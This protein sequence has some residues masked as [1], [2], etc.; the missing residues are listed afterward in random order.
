M[1]MPELELIAA[2]RREAERMSQDEAVMQLDALSPG[3]GCGLSIPGY[4][5]LS[6]IHHGAQGVVYRAVQEVTER[7]VAVKIIRRSPCAAVDDGARFQ[8]E[9]R[10]LAR[11]RHPSIVAI[12]E[13][14]VVCG[15]LYFV[16][17][18]V[19][20]TP[21]DEW[22]AQQ[23][24]AVEPRRLAALFAD[25]CDAV[26]AAHVRGVIHRD[27]KP[28]NIRVDRTATPHVLD[29]GLAKFVDDDALDDAA[30]TR[31]GQFVGSLPWASPEQ[32]EGR[33]DAVDLRTDVYALGVMLYQA[34]T[35]RFPHDTSGTLRERLNAI[36]HAEPVRARA[37][38]R[39]IDDELDT[40]VHKCLSKT[41]ERRYQNAGELCRDLRRYLAGE[42]IEAKRES[43][44]YMLRKFAYR[45]RAAVAG[46]VLVVAVILLGSVVIAVQWRL[47][48]RERDRAMQAK[49]A[50]HAARDAAEQARA[51][52]AAQRL[53]VERLAAVAREES[54]RAEAVARFLEQMLLSADPQESAGRDV[55]VREILDRASL[56]VERELAGS[57]VVAAQV[58]ET[59]GKSYESLG[60]LDLA[61]Q[62]LRA[63]V[64]ERR[65]TLG[66]EHPDTAEALGALGNTLCRR[67]RFDEARA[68]LAQA[69]EILRRTYG[70]DDRRTLDAR[71]S[72]AALE[73]AAGRLDEAAATFRDVLA[74]QQTLLGA[75]HPSTLVTL[76]SLGWVLMDRGELDAAEAI[77][78]EV[79]HARQTAL[80]PDHPQT[81]A[82][83]HG[84][85]TVRAQR[86]D[87][88]QSEQIQREVLA[89]RRRVLG[90]AHPGTLGSM[91]ALGSCLVSLGRFDEADVLFRAV[92][93]QARGADRRAQLAEALSGSAAALSGRGDHA[94]AE[95]AWREVSE[96]WTQERG[97][98]DRR[99][100]RARIALAQTLGML[101]KREEA[102]AQLREA[103]VGVRQRADAT[104]EKWINDAL[105]GLPPAPQT[106]EPAG[107]NSGDT[108]GGKTP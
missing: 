78:T 15:Q 101:G 3:A 39:R 22:I 27:L 54:G 46:G 76:E 12:H 98:A 73:R 81:L 64:E 35:G 67:G 28:T 68:C 96:I 107:A 45:Y 63:A 95:R 51:A 74:R 10:A 90:D 16:M 83:L 65:R 23:G 79:V 70:Q 9:V 57:P 69:V 77:L 102:L 21:L 36:V 25:I 14:G 61:E 89:R 32:A 52:E 71:C 104:A 60:Q 1:S 50:A 53:E 37:L 34:L 17:D 29:F 100:T 80:G 97:A 108:G 30:M 48:Q 86:G 92:I 105:D 13:T 99:T 88:A 103:L 41:P 42:P 24:A 56:Q 19:D 62:H 33:L 26:G 6:E 47:A 2:A 59:L 31:T 58:R 91:C 87:L 7:P 18:L 49:A 55:P 38:R 93:E 82:S 72:A 44:W 106:T 84:L 8:R 40:I 20:G 94:G 85:A 43:G 4:R 11:L 75:A 5:L 66:D